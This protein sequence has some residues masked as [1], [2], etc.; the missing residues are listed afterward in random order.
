MVMHVHPPIAPC[1]P[2]QVRCA[3][4][5]HTGSKGEVDGRGPCT[6]LRAGKL[7]RAQARQAT[8]MIP[9]SDPALSCAPANYV[10]CWLGKLPA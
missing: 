4:A 3:C 6:V 5:L 1:L 7:H 10:V 8:C 9:D 2:V